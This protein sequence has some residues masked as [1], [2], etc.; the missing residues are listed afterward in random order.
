MKQYWHTVID[1]WR[2]WQDCRVHCVYINGVSPASKN[3]PFSFNPVV[4]KFLFG[5]PI[6]SFSKWDIFQ[7]IKLLSI[8]LRLSIDNYQL[9]SGGYVLHS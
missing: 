5:D 7:W 8:G 3:I 1:Q 2:T 4:N 9:D 6:W